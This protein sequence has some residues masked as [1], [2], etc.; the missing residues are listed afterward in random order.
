LAN[1]TDSNKLKLT[2]LVA[3][4]LL[5]YS[6]FQKSIQRN[7]LT[8]MQM[9]QKVTDV[10]E[11]KCVGSITN[12]NTLYGVQ[13]TVNQIRHQRHHLFVSNVRAYDTVRNEVILSLLNFI[14]ERFQAD[15][16]LL[17]ALRPLASITPNVSDAELDVCHCYIIPDLDLAQFALEYRETASESLQ[18]LS[19]S[20]V[21]KQ[22][23]GATD[24]PVLATA[25]VR[26]VVS[27]SHS[28][29]VERLIQAYNVVKTQ[30]RASLSSE[31]LK[32]YLYIRYNMPPLYKYDARAAVLL[33]LND[34]ERRFVIPQKATQQPWFTSVY[35]V[36]SLDRDKDCVQCD[37][38]EF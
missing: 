20:T 11:Q 32:C 10:K 30:D 33:W 24:R 25:L 19:A 26:F 18:E 28:Y 36:A 2:C 38:I 23:L 37:T 21:L 31:T 1:L 9:S 14:T 27:K 8:L 13:L 35:D 12:E 6:R 22:L 7:E 17:S 29:D 4:I 3:D 34:R 5:I 15:D 16:V